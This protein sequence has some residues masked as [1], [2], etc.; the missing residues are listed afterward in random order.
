M[1]KAKDIK[2]LSA[3]FLAGAIFCSGAAYAASSIKVD[4]LP[5][6]YY[7]DGEQ[8]TTSKPGFIYNGTA[9]VPLRFFSESLGKEVEWDPKTLSIYVGKK[10]TLTKNV[11]EDG[12]GLNSQDEIE[13]YHTDPTL[14]D[15]DG[16]GIHDGIEIEMNLNPNNKD[17]DNNGV[18]DGEE[19][20]VHELKLSNP[21]NVKGSF[22][23]KNKYINHSVGLRE[24]MQYLNDVK[25]LGA[26]SNPITV[27]IRG[28][29]EKFQLE[30]KGYSNAKV[31]QFDT[32]NK[33]KE[34]VP[35]QQYDSNG[36]KIVFEIEN[37]S[38]KYTFFLV[39]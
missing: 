37:P 23:I 29:Y 26:I 32:I 16:D 22:Y 19:I 33:T 31:Y 25:S 28:P 2:L 5:L 10:T 27:E 13:K 8:K 17:S 34:L 4:F 35:N 7:F 12:D 18:E 14:K 39:K 11:D 3:G 36:D 1:S 15:T 30:F 6:K 9:Y 24:D 38:D 21:S 20:G